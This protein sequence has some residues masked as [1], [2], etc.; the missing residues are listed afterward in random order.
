MDH[1][2]E[3]HGAAD[4]L[5]TKKWNVEVTEMPKEYLLPVIRI[6]FELCE[7]SGARAWSL[8][9]CKAGINLQAGVISRKRG[10]LCGNFCGVRMMQNTIPM[11]VSAYTT[12]VEFSVRAWKKDG[13]LVRF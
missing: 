3:R 6:G 2:D 13:A 8:A 4:C 12:D 7:V 11:T 9:A 1:I 10:L 5:A